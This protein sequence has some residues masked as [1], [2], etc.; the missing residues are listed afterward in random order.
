MRTLTAIAASTIALAASPSLAQQVS[1]DADSAD[2]VVTGERIDRSV[3]DTASTVS[4]LDARAVENR[5]QQ[6]L[7]EAMAGIPNVAITE[8]EGLPAI[9]G[10][11][12]NSLGNS[13]AGALQTGGEQRTLLVIDDFS[14]VSTFTNTAF[15]SLFDVDQIEVYRGPQSTLRGRNAIA[16]A[17]VITT[18]EPEFT[19]GGRALAEYNYDD[20]AG[21]GYRVA[22]AVSLPIISDVLAVR[23]SGERNVDRDPVSAL[24]P[25]EYTGT[26]SFD[27]ARRIEG[28]R[29]NLKVRFEPQDGTRVDLIGNYARA[30][31]PLTR[32]TAAG[33]AQGVAFKDRVFAFAGDWRV[34]D[35]EAYFVGVKISQRVGPGDLRVLMG[36]GDEVIVTNTARNSSFVDFNPSG[37]DILTA[38]AL[39]S[40]EAGRLEGLVGVSYARRTTDTDAVAFGTVNLLIDQVSNTYAAY[41]DLR[42]QIGDAIELNLGGRVLTTS[43]LRN[44]TFGAPIIV[45]ER[46]SDTVVLPQLGVLFSVAPDQRISLSLRKGYQDGGRGPNLTLGTTYQFDPETVWAAEASYRYQSDNG[47]FGLT[48]TGFYNWYRDQQ[49]FVDL[50]TTPVSAEVRNQPRSRS[51]GLEIEGRAKLDDRFTATAGIGLLDTRITEAAGLDVTAGNRFGFSPPVTINLGAEWQPIKGLTIDGRVAFSGGYF[52]DVVND[53]GFTGGNY[54][55]ADF[56]IAYDF[57]PVTA[58]AFVQNA[59]DELAFLS[60]TGDDNARLTRPR[61]FGVTLSGEF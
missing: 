2:I 48:V 17:F 9:R 12:T 23:I 55:I 8:G 14:R 10:Q 57:G 44:F 18:R 58:R 26:D 33:P 37:D 15:N 61:T 60:R 40:F 20:V 4:V 59:F 11:Q 43:Q 56:G 49:F 29:A 7:F 27:A 53:A 50:D 45:N 32:S 39:Y 30:T 1:E 36:Y 5:S 6:S 41:A 22:G 35:T 24:L 19:F 51:F 31:V 28:N 21:D 16:G 46:V 3:L 47:L 25:G 54:A 13:P 38:E 52:G 34:L 42:Y